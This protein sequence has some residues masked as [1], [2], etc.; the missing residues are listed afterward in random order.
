VGA[1]ETERISD[2]SSSEIGR[3]VPSSKLS[4]TSILTDAELPTG[5]L[6]G[7]FVLAPDGVDPQNPVL[8]S[9][10]ASYVGDFR[11]FRDRSRLGVIAPTANG[12]KLIRDDVRGFTAASTR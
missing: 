7:M 9:V 6:V 12:S 4:G 3:S 1:L 11:R 8:V 2:I 10:T 5:E